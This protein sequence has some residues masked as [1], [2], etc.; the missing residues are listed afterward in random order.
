MFNI[1]I[2]DVTNYFIWRQQDATRNS[3]QMYGR[4][5]FSHK[6]MHG[7]SVSQIQDMLMDKFGKNWNNLPVWKRRGFCVVPNPNSYDSSHFAQRNDCIPIFT[8]ERYYIED[9]LTPTEEEQERYAFR[10]TGKALKEEVND[11]ER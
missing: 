2:D 1:P 4:H 7:K 3:I 11:D 6:E 5:F 10:I 9:R 8:K